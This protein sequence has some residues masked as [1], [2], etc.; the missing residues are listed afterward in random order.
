VEIPDHLNDIHLLKKS[1]KLMHHEVCGFN[2]WSCRINYY[3]YADEYRFRIGD[4]VERSSDFR[5]EVKLRLTL[6]L[7][8]YHAMK[9]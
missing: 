6:C 1:M 4:D 5:Q 8:T 7:T 3:E 9:I 2:R